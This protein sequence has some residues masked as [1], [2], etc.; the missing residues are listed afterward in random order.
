MQPVRRGV[1]QRGDGRRRTDKTENTGT[2]GVVLQRTASDPENDPITVTWGADAGN[3][4]HARRLAQVAAEVQRA[5]R[6][7]DAA[8]HGCR[9]DP[10]R[11][12]RHRHGDG[13]VKAPKEATES[14]SYFG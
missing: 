8:L 5:C 6:R 9:V 1:E 11:S 4:G 13:T 3:D 10:E 2:S 7:D 14:S 12:R